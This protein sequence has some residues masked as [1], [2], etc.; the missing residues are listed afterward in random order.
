[1]LDA[2][3]SNILKWHK[4]GWSQTRIANQIGCHPSSISVLLKGW[5]LKTI[6]P[7]R[8][9]P[10]IKRILVLHDQGL[11]PLQIG[12]QLGMFYQNVKRVLHRYGRKQH[13]SRRQNPEK[14]KIRVCVICAKKFG[15]RFRTQ[16]N[17]TKLY[18]YGEWRKCCSWECGLVLGRRTRARQTG[19]RRMLAACDKRESHV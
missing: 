13:T 12:R 15:P 17:S 7:P 19:A 11:S 3:H 5:G 1:M 10:R 9:L 18:P 6:V 4:M 14:L 16:R 8:N 2:H